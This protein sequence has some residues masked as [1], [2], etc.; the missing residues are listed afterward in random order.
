MAAATNKFFR[1]QVNNQ[2]V[3]DEKPSNIASPVSPMI[4]EYSSLHEPQNDGEK[5]A[6]R[7]STTTPSLESCGGDE[8]T[9]PCKIAHVES[10]GQ[11]SNDIESNCSAANSND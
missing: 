7:N 4:S 5:I 9:Y 11:A 2:I 3:S 6:A 1:Q 10:N 8:S